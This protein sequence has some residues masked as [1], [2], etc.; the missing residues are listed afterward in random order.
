MQHGNNAVHVQHGTAPTSSN[1]LH[2]PRGIIAKQWS[3]ECEFNGAK[4]RRRVFFGEKV[5]VAAEKMEAG[6]GGEAKAARY[7]L[8]F[9]HRDERVVIAVELSYA[10][11]ACE[12]RA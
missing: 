9:G 3:L 1:A 7:E 2:V 5:G 12:R 4:H 10:R 6:S 11:A 8:R